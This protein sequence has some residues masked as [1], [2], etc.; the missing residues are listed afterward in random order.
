MTGAMPS[1]VASVM[2]A[3]TATGPEDP[4]ATGEGDAHASRLEEVL[5]G[6]LMNSF[7][8]FW[9]RHTWSHESM[10]WTTCFRRSF[11][12]TSP[13]KTD[14]RKLAFATEIRRVGMGGVLF[15]KKDF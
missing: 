10:K 7:L 9:E 3:I 6:Q 5:I 11:S 1:V 14:D 15:A 8:S 2:G 13:R 4:A 12:V